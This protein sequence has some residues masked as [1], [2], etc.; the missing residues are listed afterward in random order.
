M[1]LVCEN[2]EKLKN[3]AIDITVKGNELHLHYDA[4]SCDSSFFEK[5]SINFCP[6]CGRKLNEN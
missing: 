3:R 2:S 4:F 5:V 6:S 1:C